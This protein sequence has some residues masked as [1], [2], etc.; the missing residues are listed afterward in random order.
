MSN[1]GFLLHIA[2]FV[3]SNVRRARSVVRHLLSGVMEILRRISYLWNRDRHSQELAD[4]MAFHREMTER[5]GRPVSSLGNPAL[6][7]EQAREAWG[8]TWIDRLG[9]DLRYAARMLARSPGFT[10]TATL[11]LAIGIGVNVGAFSILNLTALQPLPV[12]DPG[13]LVRLQ[14]RSPE[15]ISGQMPYPTAIFYRDHARTLSAVLMMMGARLEMNDDAK[16]VGTNFVSANFFRDLGATAAYGRLFDSSIDDAP[17]APPV[18]VLSHDYWQ[19]RFGADPSIVGKTIHL[20]HK[21][22]TIIGIAPYAFASLEGEDADVWMPITQQPY[23]IEGSKVLTNVSDGPMRVWGRLAPGVTAKMAEQE[24]LAL[25]NERRKQY[26][27]DVWKGE[28]IRSDPGD[29]LH[30]MEPQ[31]YQAV[32]IAGALTLL[33]LAVACANL[34]GLLLAR[35]VAREQELNIRLAIGANRKRIFR[36]LFTESLL[37]ALLGSAAGLALSYIAIRVTLIETDAPKWMSAAPDWRVFLF[38]LALAF[39]TALLFGFAPALQMAR[40]KHRRT[41]ARQLLIA[42][43]VAASC[44]LVIVASLLVRA[45]EHTLHNSPGF[46]YEQIVSISPGLGE[47]GYKPGAAR[48]YLDQLKQRLQSIPNVASVSLV[49]LPPL[50]NGVTRIDTEVNG[51]P[52]Q[53]YPNWIDSDFFRT[54]D[55]P[56]L[57]G[58]NFLPG[59]KDVV[60]V[61]QSMAQRQWPGENPIGKIYWDKDR[62]VGVAGN[63]RINSL[64]ED[65][66]VEVYSPAQLEDMPDLSVVFKTNDAPDGLTPACKSIVQTLDPKLFPSISLLKANFRKDMKAIELAATIVSLIGIAAMTLAGVGILGLVALTVSQR[67]KEIAIRLALGSPSGQVLISVLRQFSWPVGLGLVAGVGSTVALS[68][69]LRRILYGVSNLD[70]LSYLAAIAVLLSMLALAALLPAR[71]ALNLDVARVL[72]QE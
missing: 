46:G 65:D 2:G 5:A 71:R 24:L 47:H 64:N 48:A 18:A 44:M 1:D 25:T 72:H 61:S 62:V 19:S 42:A 52:L 16:P 40:Q 38:V 29:H 36:Q 27:N 31:M 10:I 51:H 55:I 35:G 43:Q 23:I 28:Y 17:D 39:L 34:G 11:I 12:R 33:I 30:V 45:V 68:Q 67:T 66:T 3:L 54:M 57:L 63:A 32:A 7:R 14:R 60:I 69:V 70:P 50:G 4:E 56:I 22:V 49:K 21:Q 41:L 53:I 58:R 37:L 13:S 59:E 20:N 8:W 6:L 15:I 9:Q 26:P